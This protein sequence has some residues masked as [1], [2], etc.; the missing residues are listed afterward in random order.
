[1]PIRPRDVYGDYTTRESVARWFAT[2]KWKAVGFRSPEDGEYYLPTGVIEFVTAP[3]C[4]GRQGSY[5]SPNPYY[6]RIICIPK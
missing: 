1:M 3:H 5:Y 2:H 4:K 6:Q